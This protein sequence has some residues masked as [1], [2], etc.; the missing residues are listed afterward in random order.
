MSGVDP[1]VVLIVPATPGRWD[2]LVAVLGRDGD[3]GCWCQ[4]WRLSSS[5]Y[6]K[7][8]HPESL[9]RQLDRD[10]APG[11][12]AYLDGEVAGWCSV[13]PRQDYERL[14]RSRTIKP[15]DEVPVWSIVCFTVRVGFRR[16]GVA[17]ALLTGAI[18]YARNQG[19][20]ALEAYPV[21]AEGG[22]IDVAFAYVGTTSMFE[23]AGFR[24]IAETD[25]HSAGRPRI[26]MRLDLLSR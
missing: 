11:L 23:S 17:R 22:R 19:A 20:P 26:L 3:R 13:G 9:R 8:N 14:V 21:D 2:D 4:Y 1:G 12:L 5:D 7:A 6:S 15:V 18:D 24:R 10:N 25:A 16:R